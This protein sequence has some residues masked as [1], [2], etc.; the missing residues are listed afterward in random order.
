M[1]L[2]SSVLA[3]A[4]QVGPNPQAIPPSD[5]HAELRDRPPR[6]GDEDIADSP[7]SVWLTQCLDLLAQDA[8]RAHTMAQIQRTTVS[9]DERVLANHCLGL[10]ATELSRWDEA[11][12]AFSAARAEIDESD[13]RT[14]ARFATMAGNAELA[15]GNAAAASLQFRLAKSDAQAAASAPLEAI[16][17][18]DL[19]RALVAMGLEEEALTALADATRLM[20]GESEPWLLTATL[21]R[22]LDRLD[23]AQNMIERAGELAPM[24]AEIGLEAG[25]IAILSGREEAARE[26]WLS[27]V[28]I[29]PESLAA[30]IAQDY[31][32]QL[33]DPVSPSTPPSSPASSAAVTPQ[34]P[35]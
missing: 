29:Q 34:E 15:G 6:Q 12:Q 9:G 14:R 33:G 3:I 18:A 30:Q 25:V 2:I 20:P 32:A 23:E 19:A 7:A 35:S 1:L 4:L 8:S 26:S 21:L 10:A 11:V 22:R 16:A 27:V 13:P 31:L 17:S 24:D 5:G 28:E